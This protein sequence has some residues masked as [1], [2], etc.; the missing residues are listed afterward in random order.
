MT[1]PGTRHGVFKRMMISMWLFGTNSN[2]QTAEEYA[3]R[4]KKE[5]GNYAFYMAAKCKQVY[6]HQALKVESFQ[7]DVV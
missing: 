4:R 2:A 1:G 7:W 6:Q 5:D 3:P